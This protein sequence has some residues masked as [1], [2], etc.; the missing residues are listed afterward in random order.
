MAFTPNGGP[1]TLTDGEGNTTT[2]EYYG[3]DR[4][5]KTRFPS[6]SVDGA[7]STTDYGQLTYDSAGNVTIFR[8]RGGNGT[9]FTYDAWNRVTLKNVANSPGD[10]FL[11][12]D[13]LGRLTSQGW[14]GTCSPSTTTPFPVP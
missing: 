5:S 10:P 9:H 3:H 13:N 12:W 11:A 8:E 14:T 4:L 7:S 1:A 2:Y 6:P